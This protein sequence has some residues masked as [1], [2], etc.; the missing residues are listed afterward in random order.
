MQKPEDLLGKYMRY[1][2]RIAVFGIAQWALI[3]GTCLVFI[4]VM[5]SI[6]NNVTETLISLATNIIT[7]SSAIAIATSSGYYAHSAYDKKLQ[8]KVE[9]VIFPDE[10][11][12]DESSDEEVVEDAGENG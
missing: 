9:K 6:E 10:K 1:S 5:G 7:S 12:D 3:A 4:W 8:K 2:K 11:E